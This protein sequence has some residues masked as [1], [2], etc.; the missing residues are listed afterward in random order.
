MLM[1]CTLYVHNTDMYM[2]MYTCVLLECF[3][4]CSWQ[5]IVRTRLGDNN[6][7]TRVDICYV[8]PCKRRLR[9]F[10]E[11]QRYI[12]QNRSMN[13]TIENF[14]FSKKV[15]VGVVINEETLMNNAT[16][17]LSR[18][19]RGRPP[20]HLLALKEKTKEGVTTAHDGGIKKDTISLEPHEIG[21]SKGNVMVTEKEEQL[22]QPH[23]LPV[24][25]PAI[26]SPVQHY[27]DPQSETLPVHHPG[28]HPPPVN[29]TPH[30][31]LVKKTHSEQTAM[32][33]QSEDIKGDRRG[34]KRKTTSVGDKT[35]LKKPRGRPK[36]TGARTSSGLYEGGGYIIM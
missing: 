26:S 19:R 13:L 23:S 11:I 24:I 6:G 16:E 32:E 4:P 30:P 2:Y 33:G 25:P 8:T 7:P 14:S 34:M 17:E 22:E 21:M 1:Y 20:K 36:G 27:K 35:A 3:F 12:D 18:P 29:S 10:P 28:I 5:R 15:N 9:T 31:T